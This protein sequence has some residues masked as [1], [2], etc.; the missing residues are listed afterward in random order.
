[1]VQGRKRLG[2]CTLI[3][4]APNEQGFSIASTGETRHVTVDFDGL[5]LI[6]VTPKLSGR[7]SA[8]SV[9]PENPSGDVCGGDPPVR[10]PVEAEK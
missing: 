4:R 3:V 9:A 8:R 2:A 1:M 7:A 6:R 5:T 10:G